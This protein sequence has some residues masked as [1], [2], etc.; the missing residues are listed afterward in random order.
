MTKLANS[1]FGE[2]GRLASEEIVLQLILRN[3]KYAPILLWI[4]RIAACE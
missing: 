4:V 3:R 1:I 2:V